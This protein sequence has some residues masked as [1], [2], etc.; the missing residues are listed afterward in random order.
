ML[1]NFI[2]SFFFLLSLITSNHFWKEIFNDIS[3]K[4]EKTNTLI[5][6]ICLMCSAL[7]LTILLFVL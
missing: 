2:I 7:F 4:S 6:F 3:L 1:I 5:F